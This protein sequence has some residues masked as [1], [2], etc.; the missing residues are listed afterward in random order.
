[1]AD[2][3]RDR[4]VAL[5]F[6]RAD[7]LFELD[8]GLNIVFAAG[9]TQFLLGQ[10]PS[11]LVG[12]P[13]LDVI[14]EDNRRLAREMLDAASSQGR[15][16]DV[17]LRL[18]GPSRHPNVA[19]AGYRVPDFN[20]HFFLALKVE[21][22]IQSAPR[23]D[24][25]IERV[26]GS[27]L[28]TEDSFIGTASERVTAY[29]RAGGRPQVTLLK[30]DRLD[31]LLQTLGASDRQRLMNEVGGILKEVSLGGDT[32]GQVGGDTFTYIHG[33]EVDTDEVSHRIEDAAAGISPKV[34][35]Q[36]SSHT[37]HADG[38]AMTEDQV[39]KAIAH[40][41][42]RFCAD[43]EMKSQK[44]LAQALKGMVSDTVETVAFI[45][46]VAAERDL[47]LVYMPVC[48]TKTKSVHHF[49][50]LTRF[51]Q[52]RGGSSPFHV[53]SLAEEVNIV[54]EL[55]MAVCEAAVASIN[56]LV[57]EF[58]P[59]PSVAINISGAS[60]GNAQFV[61][62]LLRMLGRAGI[63]SRRIMFEITES[64]KIEHLTE[65][66]RL[67]NIMRDRG[68]RIC[69]DDFG[70]GSASFDYLNALDVDVVK[71]DGPVVKRAVGSQK[72]T[73]LLSTMAKMCQRLGI[74]TVAEMVEDRRM[75]DHVAVCGIDL[76][77]GWFYG[78]P[79]ADP[80]EF[81]DRFVKG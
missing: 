49:E 14:A 60:V 19:L 65:V 32:A 70:A 72:G 77:Q 59:L 33:D 7:L 31:D 69:L 28:M 81:K 37:L 46:K 58:G 38:A 56:G 17:L 10:A 63:S 12:R 78:K 1:M 5:A 3:D 6:C 50:A 24:A 2:P 41:I 27:E 23:D 57:R 34:R 42:K 35:L 66:N 39:A 71:F 73:D 52:D 21:P 13:F 79:T 44:S 29:N 36:A 75:A 51:R 67:L 55:D 80:Y 25:A 8:D 22:V 16:D 47:D 26:E 40:V 53:F 62:D 11:A 4:F 18:A 9:A 76:G 30:L 64:A 74:Q 45:R 20:N 54:H 43:G 61:E 48:D 68:F 15:I